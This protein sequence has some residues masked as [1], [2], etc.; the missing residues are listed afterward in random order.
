MPLALSISQP[1]FCA[2]NSQW[3]PTKS[4]VFPNCPLYCKCSYFKIG[5][6]ENC[7]LVGDI[8]LYLTEGQWPGSQGS[9]LRSWINFCEQAGVWVW[10][11]S[12]SSR[13]QSVP[14]VVPFLVNLKA[15]GVWAL[16]IRCEPFSIP[17]GRE[18]SFFWLWVSSASIWV[19]QDTW[20]SMHAGLCWAAV[21][22]AIGGRKD[23]TSSRQKHL[24]TQP[25]PEQMSKCVVMATVWWFPLFRMQV[26]SL[27][28]QS[29]EMS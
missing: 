18:T 4:R 5:C 15:P 19:P 21:S 17:A 13:W 20:D 12:H 28:F 14:Y 10:D 29:S 6:N 2:Q 26:R 27:L 1:H 25:T 9:K 8:L 7:S 24:T 16:L 22:L 11:G 3:L 23:F